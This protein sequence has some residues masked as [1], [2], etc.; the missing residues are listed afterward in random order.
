MILSFKKLSIPLYGFFKHPKLVSCI[1][2]YFSFLSPFFTIVLK[3]KPAIALGTLMVTI[4]VLM[5]HLHM[6]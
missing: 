5:G 1:C 6:L 4:V 2:N 3:T